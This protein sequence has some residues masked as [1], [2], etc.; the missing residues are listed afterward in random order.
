MSAYQ[1]GVLIGFLGAA[2]LA[3]AIGSFVGT[4]VFR[5]VFKGPSDSKYKFWTVYTTVFV[6][7]LILQ[8]GI[9]AIALSLKTIDAGVLTFITIILLCILAAIFKRLLDIDQFWRRFGLI[10]CQNLIQIALIFGVWSISLYRTEQRVIQLAKSSNSMS[11]NQTNESIIKQ[12]VVNIS[13]PL[14]FIGWSAT[15]IDGETYQVRFEYL[16]QLDDDD[17]PFLPNASDKVGYI[18]EVSLNAEVVRYIS[19]EKARIYEMPKR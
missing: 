13:G 10:L 9:A 5:S 11:L 18:F 17:K 8:T 12:K 7:S 19:I 15:H 2:T 1:L 6:P 16:Q 14:K 4:L 3:T